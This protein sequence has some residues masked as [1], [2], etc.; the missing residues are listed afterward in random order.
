MRKPKFYRVSAVAQDYI[1]RSG[2][3]PEV[4]S[5]D[6]SVFEL[7]VDA[8]SRRRVD[9]K[10][11]I[12]AEAL[13]PGCW[14]GLTAALRAVAGSG[15]VSHRKRIINYAGS[16]WPQLAWNFCLPR[17]DHADPKRTCGRS[18]SNG[19][20][21]WLR[22]RYPSRTSAHTTYAQVK[23]MLMCSICEI[24]GMGPNQMP[25]GLFPVKAFTNRARQSA[26]APTAL[27]HAEILRLAEA[28]KRDLIAIHRGAFSGP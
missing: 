4:V 9:Y 14:A 26:K 5:P 25:R 19:F 7:E 16:G 8:T 23:P 22:R 10:A 11:H 24:L 18:M 27:S 6:N 17:K 12:W 28:L 21:A 3:L 2:K 13:T 20:V 1:A 15:T